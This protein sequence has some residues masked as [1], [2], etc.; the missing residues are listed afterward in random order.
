MTFFPVESIQNRQPKLIF[1]QNTFSRTQ[2][3]HSS[4]VMHIDGN[5]PWHGTNQMPCSPRFWTNP[6]VPKIGDLQIFFR[7]ARVSNIGPDWC[8]NFINRRILCL[9]FLEEVIRF[10]ELEIILIDLR[11]AN[12][13]LKGGRV[14]FRDLDR[15]VLV[16]KVK[17]TVF[18]G[19]CLA[20]KRA[21]T[22]V[23]KGLVYCCK[24]SQLGFFPVKI[25]ESDVQGNTRSD[26]KCYTN[27]SKFEVLSGGG[28]LL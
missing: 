7:M 21:L 18:R 15:S 8:M 22:A 19:L 6:L 11:R 12:W 2:A 24:F 1:I 25:F 17:E 16:S 3:Q 23:S 10:H 4:S 13:M 14:M 5:A 20:P 26:A 9:L 27:F 28:R